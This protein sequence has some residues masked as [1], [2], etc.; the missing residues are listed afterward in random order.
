MD[1]FLPDHPGGWVIYGFLVVGL[2][3]WLRHRLPLALFRPRL[4]LAARRCGWLL[5]LRRRDASETNTS[6][7][8]ETRWRPLTDLEVLGEYRG[9]VFHA[10]Q[11]RARRYTTTASA[12]PGL[13]RRDTY[14]YVVSLAPRDEDHELADGLTPTYGDLP[15]ALYPEIAER[16]RNIST[17]MLR[18]TTSSELPRGPLQKN[19][20][21]SVYGLR[22]RL[23]M[24]TLRGH[25]D[26]LVDLAEEKSG[27]LQPP[28]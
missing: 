1:V 13:T 5:K 7:S 15:R 11:Q 26:H 4:R 16:E 25:L 9:H 17:R 3:L 6:G 12:N 22:K 21:L 18:G 28:A 14:S 10:I 23:T 20:I 24:K 19:G 27:R 8:W 2:L